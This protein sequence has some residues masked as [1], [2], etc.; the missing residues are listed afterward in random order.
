MQRK[1]SEYSEPIFITSTVGCENQKSIVLIPQGM[2]FESNKGIWLLERGL[3]TSYIGAPVEEFTQGATVTSAVTV[4]ETNQVRFTLSSGVTLMY[5]YF[6][7]QWGSFVG[8][9]SVSSCIW[10]GLHTFINRYGDAYQES[11]G[12]YLDGSN[13]VLMKFQTGPLRLGDLQGYQRAYFFYILGSYIT[14]HKLMVSM[15]YDYEAGPS[16]S[17]LISPTNYTTPFGDGLSQSPFGQGTPFGG[18]G[19][20]E[21]WR[22]FLERQRCMAFG[23]TLQEV[24]DASFGVPAGAGLTISGLNVVCAFKQKFRPQAAANSAG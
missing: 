3:N 16:Q 1:V 18:G 15:T 9:P 2:M 7:G 11:P 8:V 17:V 14:P 23:I 12:S 4:P 5:D 10:Q 20:L 19:N 13:P 6:Y 21:S 24:Y 22:V